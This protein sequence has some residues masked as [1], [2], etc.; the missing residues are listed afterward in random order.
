[1]YLT[2]TL[3]RGFPSNLLPLNARVFLSPRERELSVL[4]KM[5]GSVHARS[6]CTRADWDE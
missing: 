6:R 4:D 2:C 3:P 5:E 1:M